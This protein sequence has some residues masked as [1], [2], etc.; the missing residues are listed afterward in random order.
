[1]RLL[2]YTPP[3][4]PPPPFPPPLS[5]LSRLAGVLVGLGSWLWRCLAGGLP[6]RALPW[7]GAPLPPPA[8][9]WF[10]LGA[11]PLGLSDRAWAQNADF[12]VRWPPIL[13]SRVGHGSTRLRDLGAR[14]APVWAHLFLPRVLFS[15][16]DAWQTRFFSHFPSSASLRKTS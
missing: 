1:M 11:G 16:H 13:W 2:A 15:R 7:L 8:L 5:S 6:V 9:L 14:R 12:S 10:S 4:P 3:P